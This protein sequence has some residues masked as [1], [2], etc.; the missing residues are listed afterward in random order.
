MEIVGMF[1]W[2]LSQL[3]TFVFFMAMHGSIYD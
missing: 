3:K 2:I 1:G